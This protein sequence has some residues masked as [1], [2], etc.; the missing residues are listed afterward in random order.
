MLTYSS[1]QREAVLRLCGWSGDK[2][3]SLA[4]AGDLL[5]SCAH[6]AAVAIF[7]LD[8][9]R[10]VKELQQGAVMARNAGDTELANVLT[11]VSVAVSGYNDSSD[12]DNSLWREMVSC[13]LSSLPH[14]A[15][16]AIF[17]FLTSR[18]QSR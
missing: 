10:A 17:S 6:K 16:R 11:M 12:N 4:P 13:S 18:D 14:P 9:R 8:M 3:A 1:P 5:A 2:V 7:R 15:L